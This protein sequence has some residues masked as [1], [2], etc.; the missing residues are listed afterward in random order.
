MSEPSA[1]ERTLVPIGPNVPST[2]RFEVRTPTLPPATHTNTYIV[3]DGSIVVIDPA[4]PYPEERAALRDAI[5]ARVQSGEHVAAIVLTHQ[6]LDHVSGAVSLQR[7]TGAPIWSHPET[8]KRLIGRIT[9]DRTIEEGE[10]L[11]SGG[12]DVEAIFTPGHAPG[13]LC[14]LDHGSRALI[15]GDMVASV[16][17]ILIDAE[18]D[19]DMTIYLASLARMRTLAPSVLLPAHGP[20]IWNADEHL[21]HYI[22]H[23]LKR[24][25][26][27]LSALSANPQTLDELVVTAYADTP[28]AIH[29]IAKRSLRA[30][31]DKLVAEGRSRGD[32]FHWWR[33]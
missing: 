18:D 10:R 33:Y 25:S 23:R 12:R 20:P 31:L 32:G 13:H 19:G 4:S 27:V 16:G 9:V 29:P 5:L 30:H 2:F 17:S 7:A 26:L 15:C 11:P 8:A 22:A 6:H 14:L 28:I 24:E 1:A 3:G 21:A